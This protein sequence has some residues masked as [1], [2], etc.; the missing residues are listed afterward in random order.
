MVN[1]GE[2]LLKNLYT[3]LNVTYLKVCQ[4]KYITMFLVGI[5]E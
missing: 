3:K 1:G 2:V 5:G 4:E